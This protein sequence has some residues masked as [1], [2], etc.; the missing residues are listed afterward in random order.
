MVKPEDTLPDMDLVLVDSPFE[1]ALE[2]IKG[3]FSKSGI[4]TVNDLENSPRSL[5]CSFCYINTHKLIAHI[6]SWM[7]NP[8]VP[9]DPPAPEPEPE[10]E[11]V[12]IVL[13]EVE[14]EPEPEPEPV[15]EPE[16]EP[17]PVKKPT[18]SK[19]KGRTSSSRNKE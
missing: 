11:P 17:E 13:E 9:E 3:V 6:L 14:E 16:P 15:S 12:A 5:T 2:C 7:A 8:P 19:R 18:T 1:E 10:P 4:N